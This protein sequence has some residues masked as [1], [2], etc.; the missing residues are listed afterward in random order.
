M[1]SLALTAY[2]FSVILLFIKMLWAI[3]V[4][5]RTRV[6]TRRFQYAEDA[7]WFG[8][9]HVDTEDEAIQRAQRLLRND[10]E[11]QPYFLAL[12]AAYVAVD[13]SPLGALIYFGLYVATRFLHAAFFLG[14]RQPH[15]FRAFAAGTVVLLIMAGHLVVDVL[16]KI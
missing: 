3:G 10:A 1:T 6:L 9:Q 5:G 11:N 12:G 7:Q 15:R 2:V 4:Q 14:Q 8:G 16:Q 13:A